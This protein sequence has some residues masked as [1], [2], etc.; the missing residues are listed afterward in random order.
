MPRVTWLAQAEA[1]LEALVPDPAVR[2]QLKQNAEATLHHVVTCTPDEGAEDGIMW[3]RGI[4]HEQERQ[5]EAGS[6]P[7]ADDDGTRCW[8]YILVYR[9]VDPAGFE[10]LGVRSNS[11]IASWDLMY[12]I[13]RYTADPTA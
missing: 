10:V 2:E 4:T 8:D 11:Q 6:L 3:R 12:G 7:D 9:P 13:F 1:E 5:I